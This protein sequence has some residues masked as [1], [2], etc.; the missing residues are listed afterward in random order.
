MHEE[1][2]SLAGIV[3]ALGWDWDMKL[4]CFSCPLDKYENCLKLTSDWAARAAAD[5]SFTLPEIESVAGLFQWIS[6][7]CPAI[8]ASVASLQALKHTMKRSAAASRKLDDRSK[9]AIIGL[10]RFFVYWNRSCPLFSGFSPSTTWEV[11]IKVDAST[12]FGAGGFCIPSFGYLIHEWSH[13]ERK[14]AMAHSE[15]A[16]RES[17]TF[18]ELLGIL[19]MLVEFAPQLAGKRVQI[20][21]DNEAAVRDLV[22]CFSGKPMCMRVIADIRNLCALHHIIPRFEHI[23]SCFN[24]IADRLSHNDLHQANDLCQSEFSRHLL[25]PTCL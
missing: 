5:D 24:M 21:S 13:D 3:N 14:Q 15:Q 23:L 10:E 1:Q 22:S 2:D 25:P 4:G 12:D 20:E 9:G 7:A 8:I 18:F 6:T 16:I 19:L 11:L 17:T